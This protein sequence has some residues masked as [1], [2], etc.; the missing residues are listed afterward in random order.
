MRVSLPTP[1]EVEPLPIAK[2]DLASRPNLP[3]VGAPRAAS[4]PTAPAQPAP[5]GRT[6]TAGGDPAVQR[7]IGLIDN[8]QIQEAVG[9]LEGILKKDPRNESALVELAMVNLLDLKQPE[10]ALGYLQRVMDENP[11]NQ[12]VLSELVSLYEEQGRLD[13]GLSFLMDVH[14]REPNSPDLSYGI[15]QMLTLQGR[16]SEAIAYLD[17]ATQSPENAVRAYRDLAEAYSRSGE[18]EHAL[19]A[20]NKA[21]TSQEKDIADKVAHGMPVSFAEERLNFTK[22]DKVRELIRMGD[23][24]NAQ[25]LIDEVDHAMPGDDSV[26]A[27]QEQVNRKRAG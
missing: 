8:G 11:Q 2:A 1:P 19:D 20:Y 27:L 15:G 13:E 9:V 7:A 3:R 21:I 5:F 12:V 16:D 26:M 23:Y 10:Q 6:A 22:L 18:S 17:K 25:G 14:A 4:S 24:D